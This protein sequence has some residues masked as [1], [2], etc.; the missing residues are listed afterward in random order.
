MSIITRKLGQG[1]IAFTQEELKRLRNF[2]QADIDDSDFT[3]QML[4]EAVAKGNVHISIQEAIQ[5]QNKQNKNSKDLK[6]TV[7]LN[8]AVLDFI[9]QKE[10]ENYQTVINQVMIDWARKQGVRV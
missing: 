9:K 7:K 2:N 4:D 8:P 3:D 10:P 1:N 5:S 6:I